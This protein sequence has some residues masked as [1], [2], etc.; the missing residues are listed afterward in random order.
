LNM[1]EIS[2]KLSYDSIMIDKDSMFIGYI[3]LETINETEISHI[4]K[5]I[6]INY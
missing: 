1:N 3:T 6:L 5:L 2:N 4:K